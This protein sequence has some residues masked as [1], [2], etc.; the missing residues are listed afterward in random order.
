MSMAGDAECLGIP[1][2]LQLLNNLYLLVYYRF[3]TALMSS[4]S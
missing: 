4:S 2:V 1:Q 3:Q